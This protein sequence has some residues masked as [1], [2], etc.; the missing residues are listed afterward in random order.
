ML[1]TMNSKVLFLA[2]ATMA[3]HGAKVY[4]YFKGTSGKVTIGP[5]GQPT[6][7]GMQS[8]EVDDKGK[9]YD[10][11]AQGKRFDPSFEIQFTKK[12]G[13]VTKTMVS[14]TLT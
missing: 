7:N 14:K 13:Q 12:P 9:V 11:D 3:V 6:T 8:Y 5:N 1:A 4:V 2:L 10:T